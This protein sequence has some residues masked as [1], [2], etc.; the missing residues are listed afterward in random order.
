LLRGAHYERRIIEP[1]EFFAVQKLFARY[2][3]FAPRTNCCTKALLARLIRCAE[4]G[5]QMGSC[6]SSEQSFGYRCMATRQRKECSSK[7]YARGEYLETAVLKVLFGLGSR[8]DVL[9]R[10]KKEALLLLEQQ[11]VSGDDTE[12]RLHRELKELT[13]REEKFAQNFSTGQMHQEL[14]TKTVEGLRVERERL[15]N[16]LAQLELLKASGREPLDEFAEV[17][18]L[19]KDLPRLWEAANPERKRA[20]CEIL[21]E[22]IEVG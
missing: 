5:S 16:Q 13:R 22:G 19:L 7:P 10:A 17:E 2:R 9:A 11:R 21:I 3:T 8:A 15:E 6:H 12:T 1:E 18:A 4:C 14:W 20:L